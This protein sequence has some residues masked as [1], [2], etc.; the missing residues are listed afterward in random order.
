MIGLAAYL[1][2]QSS[3]AAGRL[4]FVKRLAYASVPPIA[5]FAIGA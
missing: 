5:W 3:G 1:V 4:S 2:M